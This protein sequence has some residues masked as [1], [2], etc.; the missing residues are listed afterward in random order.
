M[1]GGVAAVINNP[2]LDGIIDIVSNVISVEE[3][4][5][6]AI[7]YALGANSQFVICESKKDAKAAIEYLKSS[8]RGRATFMPL[9]NIN[10]HEN[11]F[12][13]S[14]H[15]GI[16]G[17]ASELVECDEKYQLVINSLMGNIVVAQN[18]DVANKFYESVKKYRIITLT[19]EVFS[20]K[21]VG[22][23]RRGK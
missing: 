10:Y 2:R 3:K 4:F 12:D 15:Q 18:L 21:S 20:V 5:G 7:D 16:F 9:D 13:F 23:K 14:S 1:F 6:I 17:F 11:K 19:G 22:G 8:K